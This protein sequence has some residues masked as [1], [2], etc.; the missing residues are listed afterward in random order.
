MRTLSTRQHRQ[1]GDGALP[2][3]PRSSMQTQDCS[4]MRRQQKDSPSESSCFVH[5]L[6]QRFKTSNQKCKFKQDEKINHLEKTDGAVNVLS[7]QPKHLLQV[8]N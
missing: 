3:L 1:H 7:D 5:D 4:S 2:A 8:R 6:Q